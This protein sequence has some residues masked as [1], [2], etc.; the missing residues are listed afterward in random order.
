MNKKLTLCVDF[1]GVLHSY[2]TSGWQGADK[3]SD[4]PVPGA[5]E[6][7]REAVKTFNVCIFSSR[8][9]MFNGIWAMR[10]ALERWGLERDVI[11]E[12][13]FPTEKPAAFVMID[14]R[15][16]KFEGVFP[17]MDEIM[18]FVPWNKKP[19]VVNNAVK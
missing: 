8:S 12:I 1:D 3:V 17:T 18:S 5:I 4:P 7:L 16:I 15:A 6:F 9:H 10:D 14:D 13:E 2:V 11:A 19:W